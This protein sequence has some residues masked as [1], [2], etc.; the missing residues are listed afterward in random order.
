MD[1]S[2]RRKGYS[3]LRMPTSGKWFPLYISPFFPLEFNFKESSVSGFVLELT[4]IYWLH[5]WNLVGSR[6]LI[7]FT[8][9][10]FSSSSLGS[11]FL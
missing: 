6:G 3:S 1:E 8:F 11:L 7:T 2:A 10:F 5:P 9:D 4:E